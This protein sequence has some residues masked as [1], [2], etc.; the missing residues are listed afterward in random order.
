[1]AN[2][3]LGM[4]EVLLE[5]G[6]SMMVPV[7]CARALDVYRKI[8]DRLGEAETYRLL[9]RTFALRKEWETADE[10]YRDSIRLDEAHGNRLGAAESYRDLGKL[11]AAQGLKNDARASLQTSLAG[12]EGIGAQAD[13]EKVHTLI[14]DLDTA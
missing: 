5:L 3:H 9:G 14:G 11:Q 12:F 8:G 1:M 2:M 13:A 7:C 6:N 4:A 10:L